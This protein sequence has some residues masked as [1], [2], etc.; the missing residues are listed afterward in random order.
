MLLAANALL[1]FSNERGGHTTI[2]I[3]TTI[4]IMWENVFI[5]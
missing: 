2:A 5:H 4:I 1:L 3:I